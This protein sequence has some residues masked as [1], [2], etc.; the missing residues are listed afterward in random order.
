MHESSFGRFKE[1][2]NDRLRPFAIRYFRRDY[3]VPRVVGPTPPPC[4]ELG[5]KF[6][7][8]RIAFARILMHKDRAAFRVRAARADRSEGKQDH[9]LAWLCPPQAVPARIPSRRVRNDDGV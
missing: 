6:I 2:F 4:S 8:G 9:A 1:S 3:I 7:H 5:R